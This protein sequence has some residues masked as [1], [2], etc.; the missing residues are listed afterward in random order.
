MTLVLDEFIS[1]AINYGYKHEESSEIRVELGF[2]DMEITIR[3]EDSGEPFD[4]RQAPSPETHLSLTKR[5]RQI[6]GMGIH[7][8]KNMMDKISYER[9]NNKNI[10][11]LSKRMDDCMLHGERGDNQ[12]DQGK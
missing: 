2:K 8:V 5:K 10:L 11:T 12:E 3:I 6:G 1:N 4:P 9:K 7:L